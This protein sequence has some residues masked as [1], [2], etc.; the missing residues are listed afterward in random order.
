MREERN[1]VIIQI[2]CCRKRESYHELFSGGLLGYLYVNGV[3][4]LMRIQK[5]SFL[6]FSREHFSIMAN[7]SKT[8]MRRENGYIFIAVSLLCSEVEWLLAGI[9]SFITGSDPGDDRTKISLDISDKRT[10]YCTARPTWYNID[11]QHQH[12]SILATET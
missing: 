6:F 5:L 4:I 7:T 11:C 2:F 8:K 10:Q 9:I 3:K 1:S 12:I